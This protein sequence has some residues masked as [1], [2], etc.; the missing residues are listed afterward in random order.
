MTDLPKLRCAYIVSHYPS[1]THTF[2]LREV[3]AL[4]ERGV[5]V[6]TV[7]VRR[8]RDSD[9]IAPVD[10]AEAQS[11]HA[12]LPTTLISVIRAHAAAFLRAPAGYVQTLIEALRDAPIGIR[13]TAW[14]LFYF[15]EGIMLWRWLEVRRLGHVHAHHA[16]V[17]A[18]LAMIATRFANRSSHQPTHT[19]SITIHGPTELADVVGHKLATKVERADTVVATSDF[20]RAQLTALVDAEHSQKIHTIHCGVEPDDFRLSVD[21]SNNGGPLRVLSVARLS[22]RKGQETLLE[23]LAQLRRDGHDVE[24]TIVGDGPARSEVEGRAKELGLAATVNFVGALGR[25]EVPSFYSGAD[26]FCLPSFA[27]GVPTVLMEAMASGLPIVAT[28]IMGVPELVEDDCGLLVPPARADALADALARL[29]TDPKLRRHLAT[30][31]RR[32]VLAD[33][34]LSESVAALEALFRSV[35]VPRQD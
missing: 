27:E 21:R 9:I 14:Q 30:T 13:T 8:S 28:S 24:L 32:K 29:S 35:T 34:T 10:R 20:V 18:D 3:L 5:D 26:V 7:T 15:V 11:T 33:F 25:D 19:W 4:R 31:G 2:V 17:G 16:N 12:I 23:A 6:A 22:R 1:V